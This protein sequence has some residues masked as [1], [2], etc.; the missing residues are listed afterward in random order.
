M[1]TTVFHE[2][3]SEL[4]D[5]VVDEHYG[6]GMTFIP[7]L[8]TENGREG[9][10][11]DRENIEAV[12]VFFYP[13][14]EFG[15][16]LGVRRSYREA[17]DLRAMSIGRDPQIYVDRRYFPTTAVE[18]RQGD[19]VRLNSRPELPTMRITSVQRNGLTRIVLKLVH[20]GSQA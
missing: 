19:H 10:D 11:P 5:P 9:I 3:L 4:S 2:L 14:T 15:I 1:S 16:E 7:R 8:S 20:L 12:G 6:E 18:P 17:N 13:P